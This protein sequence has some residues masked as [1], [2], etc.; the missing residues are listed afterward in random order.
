M[1]QATAK[2]GLGMTGV[3]FWKVSFCDYT[4]PWI[5]PRQ[6][7][8]D[9]WSPGRRTGLLSVLVFFYNGLDIHLTKKKIQL[10]CSEAKCH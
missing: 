7:K 8:F 9:L 4:I 2:N 6:F 1:F 5:Y 3:G 10:R